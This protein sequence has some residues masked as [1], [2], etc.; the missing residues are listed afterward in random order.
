MHLKLSKLKNGVEI[1]VG[2]AVCKIWIKTVKIMFWSITQEPLG[3][4]KF[5]CHSFLDNL[6]ISSFKKM[7]INLRAIAQNMLILG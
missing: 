7:L 2:Q 3:L 6:C 1:L 5:E 4:L